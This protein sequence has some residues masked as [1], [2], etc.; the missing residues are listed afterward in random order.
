MTSE[1]DGKL[2]KMVKKIKKAV[3][4]DQNQCCNLELEQVDEEKQK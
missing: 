2:D 4:K 3:K 1:K